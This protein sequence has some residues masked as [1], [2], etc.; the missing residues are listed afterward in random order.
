MFTNSRIVAN[1]EATMS[2]ATVLVYVNADHVSKALIN[3]GAG[4]ADKFS[5]DRVV[6]SCGHSAICSG[7]RGYRR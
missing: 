2:Y 5:A 4:V 6:G 7:G 1:G 3:V